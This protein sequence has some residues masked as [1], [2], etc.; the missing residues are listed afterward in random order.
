MTFKLGFDCVSSFGATRR[1]KFLSPAFRVGKTCDQRPAG[2]PQKLAEH[3]LRRADGR[4]TSGGPID[5]GRFPVRGGRQRRIVRRA[6]PDTSTR[7]NL[8]TSCA[9]N[10][11][12]RRPEAPRAKGR[13][14][15]R[16]TWRRQ[17]SMRPKLLFNV[18]SK[19]PKGNQLPI[20]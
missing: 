2:D 12:Q 11:L 8:A 17:T 9:N 18:S 1:S 16:R 10:R 13:H 6:S 7:A 20:R 5:K 14:R 15:S 19:K 4:S 3:L